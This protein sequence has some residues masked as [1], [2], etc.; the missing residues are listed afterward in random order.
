MILK[1]FFLKTM[2]IRLLVNFFNT[3]TLI[4]HNHNLYD[5]TNF[6]IFYLY[7]FFY[8]KPLIVLW[9]NFDQNLINSTG[10]ILPMKNF[11]T[12]FLY[13]IKNYDIYSFSPLNYLKSIL[14][15]ESFFAFL[16]IN[17]TIF[18]NLIF[19]YF[20][21]RFLL[22][23][24]ALFSASFRR[25]DWFIFQN[26]FRFYK[27][28]EARKMLVANTRANATILFEGE[29]KHTRRYY[30]NRVNK[31]YIDKTKEFRVTYARHLPKDIYKALYYYYLQKND[32]EILKKKNE[33][34]KIL[35]YKSRYGPHVFSFL[36]SK[37]D[38][39][40]SKAVSVRYIKD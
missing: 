29:F 9:F 11:F 24:L 17:N 40:M 1:H 8:F 23:N 2:I 14:M 30:Q 27:G 18:Y 13:L 26:W 20:A 10:V 16:M 33:A 6:F 15:V 25:E 19:F 4:I 32:M 39:K 22:R 21:Y 12:G 7:F 31:K 37:E 36:S 35:F 38:E 5:Y 3:E 28:K 34:K